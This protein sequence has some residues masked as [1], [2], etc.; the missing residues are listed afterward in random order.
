MHIWLDIDNPKH[1]PFIKALSSELKSRGH[2][3]TIT[4]QNTSEI[5]KVLEENK[6]EAKII[7]WIISIFG[8]FEEF[9]TICRSVFLNRYLTDRKINIAFSVGSKAQSYACISNNFPIILFIENI[10]EKINP[11]YIEYD[12]FSF[13]ISDNIPTQ[14][15]IEK[16]IDLNKIGIFKGIIKLNDLKFDNKTLNE[17]I[18]QI[19]NS[20]FHITRKLE[21]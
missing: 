21:V 2:D 1:I 12:K 15:I 16:G 13:F 10:L 17:M 3:V 20:Y 8:L 7:G 9:S 14:K 19:E 5:K 11:L 6:L 4:A 18:T